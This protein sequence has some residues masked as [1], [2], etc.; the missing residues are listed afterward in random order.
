MW[1]F[2]WLNNILPSCLKGSEDETIITKLNEEVKEKQQ[3]ED[4]LKILLL[5]QI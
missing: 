2:D 5:K 1:P 3:F 4:N